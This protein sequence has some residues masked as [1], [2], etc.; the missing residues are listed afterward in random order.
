MAERREA[1]QA[2]TV[3]PVC[4]APVAA[5]DARAVSLEVGGRTFRF[6]G[7]AC[8]GHFARA[9]ERAALAEALRAGRLFRHRGRVRW[10]TA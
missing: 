8:R 7:P 4:G 5:G 2:A 10:G 1:E 6:C 3:D 9:A